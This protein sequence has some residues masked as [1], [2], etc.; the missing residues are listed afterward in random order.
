MPGTDTAANTGQGEF[1][2]PLPQLQWITTFHAQYAPFDEN[3]DATHAFLTSKGSSFPDATPALLASLQHEKANVTHELEAQ[4][5]RIGAL[6]EQLEDV[7]RDSRRAEYELTSVFIHR[8]SSPSFGHYF[9]YQRW[10]PDRPDEW[11]KYNDSEVTLVG[12]EE[13]LADTTGSTANPY[14]VSLGLFCCGPC[15]SL[16]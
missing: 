7:W 12:K 5:A 4:R 6:K 11:F 2:L 16:G 1:S 14:L 9:I 3:L 8:G 15:V 10:L 13:V